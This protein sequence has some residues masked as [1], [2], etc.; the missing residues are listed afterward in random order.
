M[1]SVCPC[2]LMLLAHL[3]WKE[4]SPLHGQPH[5]VHHL[6]PC[7]WNLSLSS[8][9]RG[10]L[11]HLLSSPHSTYLVWLSEPVSSLIRERE[12]QEG[13]SLS[14]LPLPLPLYP[15]LKTMSGKQQAINIGLMMI[16]IIPVSFPFSLNIQWFPTWFWQCLVTFKLGSTKG[17]RGGFLYLWDLGQVLGLF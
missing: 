6:G 7:H 8:D 15:T 13:V 14:I 17:A 2:V 4:Q 3:P 5:P 12:P 1:P 11:S 16:K 10:P 9:L